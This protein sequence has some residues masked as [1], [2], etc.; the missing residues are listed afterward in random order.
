MPLILFPLVLP[1]ST[2]LQQAIE[3]YWATQPALQQLTSDGKLWH[4]E[5]LEGTD[6]P[7]VEFFK[8]SEPDD[9]ITTTFRVPRASVQFNCYAS[10]DVQAMA[11]RDALMNG[12][13]R[14]P[15]SIQGSPVLHAIPGDPMDD[16]AE[17]KGPRGKDCYVAMFTLDILLT[18]AF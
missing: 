5:A 4:E 2:S 7:Y 6:L 10:T 14:A 1:N 11:I 13:S 12:F 16:K 18:Q 9:S 8:I 17:G 15:L 3:A